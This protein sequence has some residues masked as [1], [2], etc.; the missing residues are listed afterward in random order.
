MEFVLSSRVDILFKQEEL[1]HKN[2]RLAD[3]KAAILITLNLAILGSLFRYKPALEIHWLFIFLSACAGFTI[4]ILFGLLVIK[5]RGKHYSLAENNTALPKIAKYH[6]DV[7]DEHFKAQAT[8]ETTVFERDL[9][10]L[11]IQRGLINRDKFKWL[12]RLILACLIVW[13]FTIASL[14][15]FLVC[16]SSY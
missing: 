10:K 12:G 9:Q 7:L 5:P 3:Q 6:A 4:V 15:C 13:G 14:L 8:S 2:I 1:L 16:Q 11:I